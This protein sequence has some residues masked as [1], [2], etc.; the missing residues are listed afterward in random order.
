MAFLPVLEREL[1]VASRRAGTYWGRV[2]SGAVG[3]SV[4][5]WLLWTEEFGRM[6][7]GLALGR[8]VF[9]TLL[10]IATFL[11]L[12][13]GSTLT[14]DA[15]ASEK[16]EGTLGLLFLTDLRSWQIALGKLLASSLAAVYW[17]LGFFPIL[18]ISLLLGG[19]T[20]EEFF[21]SVLA[22]MAVLALSLSVGLAV[23]AYNRE[24][25]RASGRAQLV[26]L[27]LVFGPKV[28]L[29][30][31]MALGRQ[32]G[33]SDELLNAMPDQWSWLSPLE[34]WSRSTDDFFRW[35]YWASLA[36]TTSMALVAMAVTIR[37]L[38][39]AWQDRPERSAPR[40]GFL[41]TKRRL[42][43]RNLA[44]QRWLDSH[45]MGWRFL[46]HWS[47]RD[48]ILSLA[49][50]WLLLLVIGW[51]F[52]RSTAAGNTTPDGLLWP[53]YLSLSVSGQV[54]IRLWFSNEST[55]PWFDERRSG[56]MEWLLVTPVAVP[57]FISSAWAALRHRFKIPLGMIIGLDVLALIGA[58][59]Y[60]ENGSELYPRFVG[61]TLLR[62]F[63]LIM[64]LGAI[65]WIGLW[66][67]VSSQNRRP[68]GI[69]FARVVSWPIVAC[70]IVTSLAAVPLGQ[71]WGGRED[72]TW[73]YLVMVTICLGG[74]DLFCM[75]AAR[76]NLLNR[77]RECAAVPVGTSTGWFGRW[78]GKK[79]G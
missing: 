57:Q 51:L 15:I 16:R 66:V 45:P 7:T 47:P 50:T 28:V 79:R 73:T 13:V 5:G 2:A 53:A 52:W 46:R 17:L 67:G 62:W 22:L 39:V 26:L 34:A 65:G 63:L 9:S 8:R 10:G 49:G 75:L 42:L 60:L 4:L 24:S 35:R 33:A 21:R 31:V 29:Y 38:P 23:S 25:M 70:F 43:D 64:D 74:W 18:A 56:A 20:F 71:R 72:T 55:R 12:F 11:A 76:G 59:N 41:T 3:M 78:F 30:A 77:F 44:R 32:L 61:I 36:C 58:P 54:L 68:Q 19:V 27:L 69:P 37:H 14:S 40:P 48:L 1:R 6:F